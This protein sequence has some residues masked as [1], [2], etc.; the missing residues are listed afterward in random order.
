MAFSLLSGEPAV[1]ERVSTN[2]YVAYSGTARTSTT[3]GAPT[4]TAGLDGW[5]EFCA[6]KQPMDEDY[7]CREDRRADSTSGQPVTYARCE[8]RNHQIVLTRRP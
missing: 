4:M 5:I 6:L 2:T 7:A 3:A 1:I 8:S